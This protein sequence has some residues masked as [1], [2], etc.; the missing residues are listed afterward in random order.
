MRWIYIYITKHET[1]I[2]IY[3]Y[4]IERSERFNIV[5]EKERE[6]WLKAVT[7]IISKLYFIKYRNESRLKSQLPSIITIAIIRARFYSNL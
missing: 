4:N 7:K 6:T 1:D 3:I 2:Y 5:I